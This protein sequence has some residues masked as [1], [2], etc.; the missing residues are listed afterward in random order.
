MQAQETILFFAVAALALAL[1]V[2]LVA[3]WVRSGRD[4]AK[5]VESP[6]NNLGAVEVV[7]EAPAAIPAPPVVHMICPTCR[8]Q[9]AGG[10]RYCPYDARVLTAN[11]HQ[12]GAQISQAASMA[13]MSASA[14][15]AEKIC[16]SCSRRYDLVAQVCG[17]DGTALV[18]VN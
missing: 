13:S 8:R 3:P 4:L 11:V 5:P 18:S 1:I 7:A 16:P 6:P 9:F 15:H 2:G 10:L 14:S 17:R 12:T